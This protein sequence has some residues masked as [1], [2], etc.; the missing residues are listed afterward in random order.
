MLIIL[1]YL[2]SNYKVSMKAHPWLTTGLSSGLLCGIGDIV[3][4]E[5][6]EEHGWRHYDIRRT[7]KMA[8]IG[9]FFTGPILRSWYI[10]LD[11]IVKGTCSITIAKK[12]HIDQLCVAPFVIGALFILS[13]ELD[14]KTLSDIRDRLKTSYIDTLLRNYMLWPW[15]QGLN[16]YFVPVQ[17]RVIVVNFVGIFWNTYLSWV[18]NRDVDYY[19]EINK[20]IGM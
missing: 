11:K 10:L 3:S 20:N 17:Y 9:C 1:R 2:A 6:V 5:L 12:V 8:T 14:G 13:D 7:L 16:F 19:G 4:Q 18:L 15:V